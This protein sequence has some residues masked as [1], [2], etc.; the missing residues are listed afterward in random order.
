MC[1]EERRGWK[2]ERPLLRVGVREEVEIRMAKLVLYR[3]PLGPKPG[4]SLVRL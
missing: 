1:P 4:L 2:G 3:P